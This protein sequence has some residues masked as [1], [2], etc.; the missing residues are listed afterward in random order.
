MAADLIRASIDG[1]L[2]IVKFLVEQGANIN[3]Q[4]NYGWTALISAS[5][6][7]HLEIVKFLVE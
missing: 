1:D 6:N 3:Y 7:G 5:R 4:N 2:E